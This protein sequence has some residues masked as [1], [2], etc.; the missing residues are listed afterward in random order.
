MVKLLSLLSLVITSLTLLF[1]SAI[2]NNNYKYYYFI[3]VIEKHW[4]EQWLVY[5]VLETDT[6]L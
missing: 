1:L 5:A 2:C 6:G 3:C 4:P